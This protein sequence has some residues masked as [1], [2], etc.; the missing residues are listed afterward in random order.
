M[1]LDLRR[2]EMK[3]VYKMP[4]YSLRRLEY[5]VGRLNRKAERLGLPLVSITKRDQV[6]V[7]HRLYTFVEVSGSAPVIDGWR[8]VAAVDHMGDGLQVVRAVDPAFVYPERYRGEARPVCEHCGARKIKKYSYILQDK[9]TG[10]YKQVGKTCLQDFTRSLDWFDKFCRLL[11]QL[12]DKKSEWFAGRGEPCYEVDEVILAGYLEIT[13]N[14]FTPAGAGGLSSAVA[15]E[16]RILKGEVQVDE[17]ALEF[18][19]DFKESIINHGQP[20]DYILNLRALFEAGFVYSR[21][22]SL[23]VGAVFTFIR[24]KR[25]QQ[26]RVD[27]KEFSDSHFGEIGRRYTIKAKLLSVSVIEGYY[28]YTFLHR[29]IDEDNRLLVWFG[30][31][32]LEAEDGD[33]VLIKATV[34]D[35]TE[36]NG[37][38]QTKLKRVCKVSNY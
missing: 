12:S 13:E 38:K 33:E 8:L 30:S 11:E 10:E 18:V 25:R 29:F 5:E 37:V 28:G 20:N 26:E 24:E 17:D 2:I 36:Y 23:I 35:H 21:Q 16:R 4:D 34:D 19:R 9:A 31:R 7:D 22:I 6:L 14:G 32:R 27:K 1:H 3:R 15:S